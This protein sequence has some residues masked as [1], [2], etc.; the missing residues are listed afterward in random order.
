MDDR[1]TKLLRDQMEKERRAARELAAAKQ[2][3]IQQELSLSPST[4]PE[5]KALDSE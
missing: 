4:P 3:A 2:A 5:L 1:Q